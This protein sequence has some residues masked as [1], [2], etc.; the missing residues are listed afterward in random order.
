M[1]SKDSLNSL[2]NRIAFV[3]LAI[4]V[5]AFLAATL[6]VILDTL[7]QNDGVTAMVKVP[8]KGGFKREPAITSDLPWKYWFHWQWWIFWNPPQRLDRPRASWAQILRAFGVTNVKKITLRHIDAGSIPTNMD[9]PIQRVKLFDM[10]ILA[11]TMGFTTIAIDAAQ[12]IS[13]PPVPLASLPSKM[14]RTSESWPTLPHVNGKQL[15]GSLLGSVV[16]P[17]PVLTTALSENWPQKKLLA[18]VERLFCGNIQSKLPELVNDRF[19]E[20]KDALKTAFAQCDI[21]ALIMPNILRLL[22]LFKPRKWVELNDMKDI[23]GTG[24]SYRNENFLWMQVLVLDIAIRL[25]IRGS[26]QK[27]DTI[28]TPR[29]LMAEEDDEGFMEAMCNG[30]PR[31]GWDSPEIRVLQCINQSW[32]LD[33]TTNEPEQAEPEQQKSKAKVVTE[34]DYKEW[35]ISL[36]PCRKSQVSTETR[37]RTSC[38]FENWPAC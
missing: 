3:A 17:L 14:C 33:S 26:P 12:R 6:Q 20:Y 28:F 23:R 35:N 30:D 25:I 13:A 16:A 37:K 27:L 36:Q 29:P 21:N 5:V 31:F 2:A 15:F 24:K 19:D 38:V 7:S 9:I 34:K 11:L 4:A 32:T 10:G 1:D 18:E 8:T 22:Q